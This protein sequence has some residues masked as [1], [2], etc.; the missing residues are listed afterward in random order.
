MIGIYEDIQKLPDSFWK[1]EKMKE[2]KN[3]IK[4]C[5]GLFIEARTTS[6]NVTPETSLPVTLEIINR[7]S[8][9]VTLESLSPE[10]MDTTYSFP[11]LLPDNEVATRDFH[12]TVP[13]HL[14][15]PYWLE[16]KST[17][18]HVCGQ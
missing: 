16:E 4:N 3:L 1:T 15:I 13:D 7:S 18:R 11:V 8:V 6:V 9:K 14:S 10:G 5:L 2:C 12:V 17:N